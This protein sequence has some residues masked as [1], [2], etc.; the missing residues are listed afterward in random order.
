MKPILRP[1]LAHHNQYLILDQNLFIQ[2]FSFDA[3]RFAEY[4]NEVGLG[5]DARLSFP[6]LVGL[7]EIVIDIIEG[8]Q[9]SFELKGVARY[10]AHTSSQPEADVLLLDISSPCYV[11]LFMSDYYNEVTFEKGLIIFFWDSTEHM[12]LQERLV[13]RT[14]EANLLLSSLTA[15]QNYIN[16]ILS[17][18]TDALLV[19]TASGI[20]KTVNKAAQ[21]L[22]GY[23]QEELINNSISTIIKNSFFLHQIQELSPAAPGEFLKDVEVYC[24]TKTGEAIPI[25]FSC[26]AIETEIEGLRNFVYIGRDISER[27]QVEA[28]MLK[29]LERERELQ[30]LKSR[31]VSMASHE[32]RTPLTS[33]YSSTEL[34]EH[35]GHKWAEEKKIKYYYKIE[36]AVKRMTALLDDVLIYTKAESGKLEFKP[37]PLDLEIFCQDLVEDI[38]HSIGSSYSISFIYSGAITEVCLD[39]NLLLQILTNLLT[40]AVKYSPTATTVYF[41][42][43]C[44]EYEA[45]FEVEDKGIGIP[46]EDVS[47]LFESFH[48]GTNVGTIPGTGLGL[49]IV[50]KSVEIHGGQITV[51]SE[52]GV[53][54]MFRVVLPL[55]KE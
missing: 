55:Q 28:E 14:N 6:E 53:G 47:Q 3:Q 20:I 1:Y 23:S 33:I 37:K 38:Q 25:S 42:C 40:N 9:P 34:L 19:T 50:Q 16:Q 43:F 5:K 30:E 18:M 45:I 39:Q 44:E 4:P 52:V 51:N 13:Q 26:S 24:T 27:K 31:F 10:N 12:V 54:T 46:P 15:S 29:A 11:D 21:T 7:E 49:A 41:R 17:S 2:E 32:F 8:R 36:S 22:F 35:F 48:R